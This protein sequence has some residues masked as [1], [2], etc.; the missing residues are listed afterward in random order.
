MDDRRVTGPADADPLLRVADLRTWFS[1]TAGIVRAVDGVS[2]DVGRGEVF[3][4]VGESGSGK[5][6]T[7]QS[8]VG[9]IPAHS[10]RIVSGRVTFEG[11][12]LRQA[13][14]R[15]LRQLRG[16]SI[17]M[18]F[19]DPMTSLNPLFTIGH[20]LVEAY[21][22]HRGGPMGAAR[23]R[24]VEALREVGIADAA[25]RLEAYPH[26]FSGGMRQRVMIAMAMICRPKLLIADEPTTALDVTI[27]AQILELLLRIR[28]EHGVSILLI[29]HD[30]GV[31]A[32]AADRVMVMYAGQAHERAETME[33]FARARGPYTWGLLGSLPPV[34][35]AGRARLRP[36]SGSPP[37]LIEPASGCRFASRCRFVTPECETSAPP[38][39]E[40]SGD[41]AVRCVRVTEPDWPSGPP[42]L[43]LGRDAPV[44][45][46]A[47]AAP[48]LLDVDSARVHFDQRRK[49]FKAS[50]SVLAVDG[51]SIALAPGETVGLVG[52]SGCGKSTLARMILRLAEPTAGQ[53]RFGDVDLLRGDRKAMRDYRQQVQMV[54]QDPYSSLD[55]RMTVR[56]I[57]AE[58]LRVHHRWDSDGDR[59]LEELTEQ[60]GLNREHL[61]RYPHEFS[62]GQRQRIGIARALVLEPSAIV[63]DEPVSALD[64]SIQAQILNLLRD[65]QQTHGFAMLFI[66]HNLSVVRYMA[67]RIAV[68]YLGRIVEEGPC[69]TLFRQPSHPYTKALLSAIPVADPIVERSRARIVL[70]GDP[71]S[72]VHPPSGCR[73]HPRCWRAEDRCR[74]DD[75]ELAP[76]GLGEGQRAACHFAD[77][78][79]GVLRVDRGVAL[80]VTS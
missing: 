32:G 49:W 68:M 29:T 8:I 44:A 70:G 34:E 61:D 6:I 10:G 48:A 16:G 33:L 17:G 27:Q 37:S 59:R 2:F 25:N 21:R 42:P 57:L 52:E 18:V 30:L 47:T 20:Q 14:P 63:L 23:T 12:D 5:S 41:H 36:I 3:G 56:E 77:P 51:V 60:V 9:L 28:D 45:V 4:I 73:F 19:Q 62:G 38:L 69:E 78:T 67:D 15:R 74:T 40:L 31:V 76:R 39:V 26:E 54:F 7:A 46:A 58:P 50:P 35:G 80:P 75:P 79:P 24:A 65:L 72:P 53:L 13:S 11:E 43:D 1:T 55:P 22:I 66:A 71:P 64:V